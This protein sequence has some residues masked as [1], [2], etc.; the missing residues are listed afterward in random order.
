MFWTIG[1]KTAIGVMSRQ[2]K[3]HKLRFHS[4]SLIACFFSRKLNGANA[5]MALNLRPS[6]L[7]DWLHPA[8]HQSQRL[9][10]VKVRGCSMQGDSS[11][12]DC[13]C[14]ASP[15]DFQPQK[16]VIKLKETVL[17]TY[18][19]FT[20]YLSLPP[21]QPESKLFT[22]ALKPFDCRYSVWVVKQANPFRRTNL[23]FSLSLPHPPLSQHKKLGC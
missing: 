5:N 16:S 17:K 11:S 23:S 22:G 15:P 14:R 2:T 19:M 20:E 10:K 4:S 7:Q 3:M 18:T 21:H 9:E 6:L 8:I 1:S 12:L 13:G